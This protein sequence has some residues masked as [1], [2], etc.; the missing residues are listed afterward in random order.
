MFG[1]G[2]VENIEIDDKIQDFNEIEKYV[3]EAIKDAKKQMKSAELKKKLTIEAENKMISFY[4][5]QKE[6]ELAKQV[7]M[8][9]K[10]RQKLDL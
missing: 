3:N 5:E 7:E 10:L 4:R 9:R 8:S 1:N 2:K 6:E